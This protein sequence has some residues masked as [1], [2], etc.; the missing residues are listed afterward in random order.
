MEVEDVAPAM[1][2]RLGPEATVGLL[3]LFE[4]ARQEWTGDVTSTI[5]ERFERR[6]IDEL[7]LIRREMTAG[8]AC[9]REEMRDL[10]ASLREEMCEGDALVRDEIR[11]CEAALRND[12]REGDAAL[13]LEMRDTAAALREE[14]R[15]SDTRRGQ[16]LATLKLELLKWSSG[17]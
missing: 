7:G 15:S 6:L 13:R 11:Q 17:F 4:T 14:I 3:A 9:V 10:R 16:E 1:Q 2:E 5:V 12:T 8:L